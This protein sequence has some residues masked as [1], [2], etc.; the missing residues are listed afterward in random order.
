MSE[1]HGR[2]T[3]VSVVS[4]KTKDGHRQGLWLCDCG[5]ETTVALS[6][7]RNGYTQS[8][9]CLSAETSRVVNRKHGQKG[10]PEY[11]SWGAM[12]SRCTNP[13]SKDYPRYG[14]A[15]ITVDPAFDSFETFLSEIGPRPEGTTLDRIDTRF[16]YRPGNVRWSTPKAQAE[17][18]L[19]TNVVE[20]NGERFPSVE[21]AAQAHGVT[22]TTVV[23]WCDGYTDQRRLA[24]A[25]GGAHPP[26]E[27]CRRWK[28]YAA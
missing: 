26:R 24:Q 11:S 10:T 28:L 23:R 15:G 18:T 17:N 25:N 20:I 5:N 16:G 8:C 2:L 6:R 22:T 4:E 9:G 19:A 12:R 27:G 13:R 14:G 1:R 7:V 3:L 21:A